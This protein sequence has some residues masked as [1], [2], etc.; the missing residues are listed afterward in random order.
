MPRHALLR[1][2][3]AAAAA[4]W[5][6]RQRR[7]RGVAAGGGREDAPGVFSGLRSGG[8]DAKMPFVSPIRSCIELSR[9]DVF[10]SQARLP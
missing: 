3:A 2:A 10:A 9:N 8:A 1:A 4:C 5:G 6:C 7:G